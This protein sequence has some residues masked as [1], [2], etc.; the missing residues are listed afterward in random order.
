MSKINNPQTDLLEDY[1]IALDNKTRTYNEHNTI[2]QFNNCHDKYKLPESKVASI[3][4]NP[5]SNKLKAIS[6]TKMRNS[7]II[8]TKSMVNA[9]AVITL[10]NVKFNNLQIMPAQ[11]KV[12]MILSYGCPA[13][14]LKPYA[15]FQSTNIKNRGILP[16]ESNCTFNKN[17]V[18]CN[19]EPYK[20]E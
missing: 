3:I 19:D 10:G 7:E 6:F 18:S 9:N 8:E 15:I 11:C 20:L 17:Y 14:T 12:D 13:C 4:R 16:F 5:K 2:C 1:Q